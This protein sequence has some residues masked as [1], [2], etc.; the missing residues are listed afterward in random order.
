MSINVQSTRWIHYDGICLTDLKFG[1]D[2]TID[3]LIPSLSPAAMDGPVAAGTTKVTTNFLDPNGNP[4]QADVTTANHVKATWLGKDSNHYPP[5]VRKNEQ[6]IVSQYGN[7]DKFFWTTYGRD[8]R[9]RTLDVKRFEVSATPVVGQSN[10]NDN[11]YY[12]EMN[13]VE[14]TLRISTSK[15]NNEPFAYMF[16]I[17]TKN[18]TISLCDD[19]AGDNGPNKVFIDSVKNI[20]HLSNNDGTT[21]H[22][23]ARNLIIQAPDTFTL[24]AGKQ[25]YFEAPQYTFNKDQTGVMVNNV[26]YV[27]N[28]GFTCVNNYQTVGVNCTGMKITGA[29]VTGGVRAPSYVTGSVGGGYQSSTTDTY[30]VTNTPVDNSPDTDVSGGGDRNVAAWADVVKAFNATAQ[31]ITTVASAVPTAAPVDSIISAAES[32]K[33]DNI[34][35]S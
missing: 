3:V 29:L 19:K 25:I 33:I 5:M 20:I 11:T 15:K 23:D 32:S 14:G 8:S 22:A 34:K 12:I 17:D 7:S 35:G 1:E 10:N 16:N 27:T 28:N 26:K 6:V 13:A 24:K 30:N 9:L 31:A 2:S 18:G 4:Q 21:Y